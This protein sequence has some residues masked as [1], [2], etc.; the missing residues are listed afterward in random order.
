MFRPDRCGKLVAGS[1]IAE[2]NLPNNAHAGSQQTFVVVCVGS[3]G[4]EELEYTLDKALE[5]GDCNRDQ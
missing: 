3:H 5:V 4:L 1:A 2:V